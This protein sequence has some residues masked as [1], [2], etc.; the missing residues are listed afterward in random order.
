MKVKTVPLHITTPTRQKSYRIKSKLR[1]ALFISLVLILAAALLIQLIHIDL[2]L[3]SPVTMET[4]R[5]TDGDT[6][7]SIAKTAL[8]E[9]RDI[10]DFIYELREVNQLAGANIIAGQQLMIPIYDLGKPANLPP[11]EQIIVM[12]IGMNE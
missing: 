11:E 4:I 6:L 8:P 2:K 1:L 5:V 7:W 10:R 12:K 9:G 3:N